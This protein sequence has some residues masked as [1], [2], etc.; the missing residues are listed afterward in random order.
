MCRAPSAGRGH[1][2]GP[3]GPRRT[4]PLVCHARSALPGRRDLLMAPPHDLLLDARGLSKAYAG[5]HALRGASFELRAGEVHA[6]VGENGAGKSTL[7]QDHHRSH[8]SRRRG[9]PPPAA[10]PSPTTPRG[11]RGPWA[12][13][14]STSS[15]RSSPTSRWP[16]TWRSAWSRADRGGACVGRSDVPARPALLGRGRRPDR[17]R[18][19]GAL[20]SACRSSSSWRSRAR[21][22]PGPGPH[23]GRADGLALRGGHEEPLRRHPPPAR[24]GGGHH[25]HL[26][27]AGGASRHRR[28]RDGLARR[29][30]IDTR[31]V[32][33]GGPRGADPAHGGP[34]ARRGLPQA[35]GRGGR[36]G[37]RASRSRQPRRGR[38][39]A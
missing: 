2:A 10:R 11:G 12:S 14:P 27:S 21:S 38:Q 7:D 36:R 6:L 28:P 37:P 34:R 9:S 24:P 1:A 17:P 15:P 5:V 3:A 32:A 26:S 35:G 33:Y 19:G 25:L 20:V 18:D 16:R 22:G 30:T 29:R 13:P 23:P 31:D 39:A 8:R 4:S